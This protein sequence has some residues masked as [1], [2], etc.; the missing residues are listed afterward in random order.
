M[1]GKPRGAEART[2][3]VQVRMTKAGRAMLEKAR[4]TKTIS[5][6][7]RDLIA[8]DVAKRKVQ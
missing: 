7:I 3:L 2:T 8:A 1:A 6:Y 5:D 4:G